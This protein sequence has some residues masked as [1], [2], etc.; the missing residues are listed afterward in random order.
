MRL[1]GA[2]VHLELLRNFRIRTT[3]Q[4]QFNDLLLTGPQNIHPFTHA[5]TLPERMSEMIETPLEKFCCAE[6]LIFDETRKPLNPLRSRARS[7]FCRLLHDITA[8]LFEGRLPQ[9]LRKIVGRKSLELDP[10]SSTAS[11][12]LGSEYQKIIDIVSLNEIVFGRKCITGGA[13]FFNHHIA[14]DPVICAIAV[15]VDNP[16]FGAWP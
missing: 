5:L 8:V 11:A 1:N 10:Q 16:N 6:M 12:R 7:G 13:S 4:Q 9:N 2:M 14:V 3:L 15:A